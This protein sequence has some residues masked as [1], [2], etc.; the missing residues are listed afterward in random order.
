MKLGRLILTHREDL[1][2]PLLDFYVPARTDFL[3]ISYHQLKVRPELF[4]QTENFKLVPF[5]GPGERYGQKGHI[6]GQQFRVWADVVKMFPAIEGWVAHD[7]D[8]LVKPSDAD[9]FSH[10]NQNQYAMAGK[11]IPV[12][13]SG[14]RTRIT[15]MFP[16]EQDHQHWHHSQDTLTKSVEDLIDGVLIQNFPYTYDGIKTILGGYGD[17]I[18]TTSKNF[19]LLA[20]EKL[21]NITIGGSEQ[22]PQTIFSARG[23]QP[24]DFRRY[25]SVKIP[26]INY[27][28][29]NNSFDIASP[30][31]YWPGGLQP[32]LKA[33][34][35]N[36]AR[37]IKN[38]F[39]GLD[40]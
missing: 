39:R 4:Q 2:K 7:Y 19:Q 21:K 25:Y 20:D 40:Y 30:V 8:V 22:V 32:T 10:L 28:P 3:V 16:F 33:R 24:V 11:P 15:D 17:I 6:M 12:W 36:F 35:K 29:F 13:Q 31:K 9:I 34:L 1:I 26:P 23:I 18:A 27:V 38:F 37:R 5:Y 14:M